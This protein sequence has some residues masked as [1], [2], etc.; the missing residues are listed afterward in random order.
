MS[1]N[2]ILGQLLNSGGDLLK[3][4][5]EVLD[6][7]G[8]KVLAGGAAAGLLMT[9]T[10]RG[11]LKY[12]GVAAL[13]A[14]AYHAWQQHQA[15]KAAEAG[16][17]RPAAPEALE[18]PPADSGFVPKSEAEREQLAKVL[19][20]AMVTAAKADGQIDEEEQ[21]AMIAHSEALQMSPEEQSLLFAEMGKPF[22][23]EAVVQSADSPEVATEVYAASLV[24]VGTPSPA[25]KAYLRT[26]AKRLKLP[27]EVVGSLHRT[28]NAA[29]A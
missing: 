22:D 14:L 25:E 1:L 12:G 2:A 4:G 5:N 8:K 29:P 17:A 18:P 11:A 13:G 15:A 26:L 24:A 21:T 7:P 19:I 10:G 9:S 3:K 16:A 23:M 6:T 28:L 20:Q 27:D